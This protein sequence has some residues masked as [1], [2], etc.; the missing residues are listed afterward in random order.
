MRWH[1]AWWSC[2]DILDN[3]DPA[4][5]PAD[6]NTPLCGTYRQHPMSAVHH[7]YKSYRNNCKGRFRLLH[8]KWTLEEFEIYRLNHEQC[9]NYVLNE[10]VKT[11]YL[12]LIR[13]EI[14][15]KT[16]TEHFVIYI[17]N[18]TFQKTVLLLCNSKLSLVF[19]PNKENRSYRTTP[20]SDLLNSCKDYYINILKTLSL[21]L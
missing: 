9:G 4:L 18:T 7:C 20:I 12:F 8:L 21:T 1:V 6:Q 11:I 3:T 17:Q 14:H 2:Y 16:S 10:T 15:L 5:V 13:S 19:L